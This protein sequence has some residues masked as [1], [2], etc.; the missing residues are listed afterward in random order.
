MPGF[1]GDARDIVIGALTT[2]LCAIAVV[3]WRFAVRQARGN[4]AARA[5]RN[6]VARRSASTSWLLARYP[7]RGAGELYVTSHLC[8]GTRTPLYSPQEWHDGPYAPDALLD[9]TDLQASQREIDPKVLRQFDRRIP[10]NH[11]DGTPWNDSVLVASEIAED[12]RIKVGIADYY[13][14]LSGCGALMLETERALASLPSRTPI[15]NA[16]ARDARS[17][18]A[19]PLGAHII[20]ANVTTILIDGDAT[21]VLIQE[22]HTRLAVHPGALNVAPVFGLL[23]PS[24]LSPVVD[25]SRDLIREYLEEFL[26]FDDVQ[27]TAHSRR[28]DPDWYVRTE[29]ARYL[30]EKIASG[31]AELNILG[32]GVDLLNGEVDLA[33]CLVLRLDDFRDELHKMKVNW[34]YKSIKLVPLMSADLDEHVAAGQMQTGGIQS[35]DLAR[36]W[37]SDR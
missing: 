24:A 35:L 2:A 37:M 12:G 17:L 7:D 34:E 29:E 9:A 31:S 21:W 22:R 1:E 14:F 32:V 28:I 25:I 5:E 19:C 10:L 4:S 6:R 11:P 16:Y 23:A 30:S 27:Y 13:Q 8:P 3:V 26:G 20:G 33:C 15:R 18:A 36:K